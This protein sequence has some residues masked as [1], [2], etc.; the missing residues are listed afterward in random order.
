MDD[1]ELMIELFVICLVGIPW[2]LLILWIYNDA[3]R[4]N[5]DRLKWTIL[6]AVFGIFAIP[7]YLSSRKDGKVLC[8]CGQYYTPPVPNCPHCGRIPK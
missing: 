2:A 8:Q 1:P 5:E 4:W 6:S 3:E 7:F